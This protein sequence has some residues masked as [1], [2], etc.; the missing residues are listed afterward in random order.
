MHHLLDIRADRHFESF[1]R[2]KC[3][4][5]VLPWCTELPGR[6]H[7]SKFRHFRCTA[8]NCVVMINAAAHKHRLA[9]RCAVKGPDPSKL[10]DRSGPFAEHRCKETQASI[11]FRRGT[12]EVFF[13]HKFAPSFAPRASQ[14]TLRA[15]AVA[16]DS[17]FIM[18]D[19]HFGVVGKR[20]QDRDRRRTYKR[21]SQ[22]AVLAMP[23]QSQQAMLKASSVQ[24][25]TPF[26]AVGC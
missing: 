16:S 10:F 8:A 6:L 25:N 12:Q 17:W 14:Q 11:C 24:T 18:S 4:Q 13:V 20:W 1:D 15:V 23:R 7:T 9:C 2:R 21:P 19:V 22:D 5:S 3:P 26:P